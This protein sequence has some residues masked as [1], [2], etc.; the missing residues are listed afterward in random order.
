MILFGVQEGDQ[1]ELVEKI[2]FE[3]LKLGFTLLSYFRIYCAI[4][5]LTLKIQQNLIRNF[6]YFAL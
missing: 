1:L 4:F 6:N 2:A 5:K 3:R